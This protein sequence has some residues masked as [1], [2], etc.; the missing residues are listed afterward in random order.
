MDFNSTSI[1]EKIGFVLIITGLI[2]MFLTD[3][4]KSNPIPKMTNG[5]LYIAGIGLLVWSLGRKHRLKNENM[6]N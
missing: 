5:Y 2:F 1:A 4:W 3:T 6:E